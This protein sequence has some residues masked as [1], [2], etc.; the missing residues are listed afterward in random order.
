MYNY[1]STLLFTMYS[2]YDNILL[3]N[4]KRGKNMKKIIVILSLV[5]VIAGSSI[6]GFLIGKKSNSDKDTEKPFV[7]YCEVREK[8]VIYEEVWVD[9][10]Y[11][12]YPRY[13]TAKY[14]LEN[15]DITISPESIEGCKKVY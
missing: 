14:I 8:G 11:N 10:E 2:I 5:I 7:Y 12:D 1:G 4:N 6:G 15:H 13:Y 3:F 9:P